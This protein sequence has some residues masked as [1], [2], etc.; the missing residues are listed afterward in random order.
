MGSVS[1]TYRLSILE[2]GWNHLCSSP[3]I[4]MVSA[5]HHT[6]RKNYHE[7]SK[8]DRSLFSSEI[9]Q[10]PKGTWLLKKEPQQQCGSVSLPHLCLSPSCLQVFVSAKQM[11]KTARTD[12]V[13]VEREF[14]LCMPV[15]LCVCMHAC[16]AHVPLSVHVCA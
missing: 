1:T 2:L 14:A 10:N 11:K 3:L 16:A 9:T 8:A 6:I 12:H 7:S 4:P 15:C 13:A 5:G